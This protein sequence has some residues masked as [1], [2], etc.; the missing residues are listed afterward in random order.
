MPARRLGEIYLSAAQ[1][2]EAI[3]T[4][5]Y[6]LDA[7]TDDRESN[8]G[9]ARALEAGLRHDAA[10]T[11][12]RAVLA[13]EPG[14]PEVVIRLA[15][16]YLRTG[17]PQAALDLVRSSRRLPDGKPRP[18]SDAEKADLA[19]LEGRVLQALGDEEG[20]EQ[21]YRRAVKVVPRH[22]AGWHR[23]G[24]LAL[25]QGRVYEAQQA[26][27]A[28]SILAPSEP[29]YSVDL[30]RAFAAS[31]KPAEWRRAPEY[32]VAAMNR[33][34]RYAPAHYEAALWYIRQSRWKEALERLQMAAESEPG[35]PEI[36]EQLARVMEATGRRA[37]AL[38][39]RGLALDARS[40]RAAALVQYQAWMAADPGNPEAPLQVADSYFKMNQSHRAIAVLEKA[41]ARWPREET[42]RERLAAFY[43]LNN[44][45]DKA[46]ALVRE[47]QQEQP[48]SA[49]ATWML[50]RAAADE[51]RLDEALRLQEQALA[52]DPSN[53]DLQGTLGE[54][55]LKTTRPDAASRAVTALAKAASA[56]P[57]E[58]RWRTAL[59]EA[60]AKAGRIEEARRQALRAL[61]LDPHNGPV[62]NRVVQL[63]RQER[64]R[65]PLQLYAGLVRGV[66]A[67]LREELARWSATWQRPKD[68]DAYQALAMFLIRTG[69]LPA[70]EGQ[71]REALRLRPNW[72]EAAKQLAMVQRLRAVL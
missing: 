40:L 55:L 27:G 57:E 18:M 72:P 64:A 67:G 26:L 59:S 16:L 37:E 48:N 60:L 7:K 51:L 38:R 31:T 45:R 44:Q 58:A 24:L 1:P 20:A 70:A 28:A 25:A 54:L 68:P 42:L 2:F 50:A 21:S 32:F 9:L 23:R 4:F 65:P 35:N 12:L 6:A 8:L 19:V 71:L 53:G 34:L 66:E 30:G 56:A 46:R 36:Q 5:A 29:R 43:L 22:A 33:S 17:R 41:R 62:Y 49:L 15:E 3:W 47:W 52:R 61:D 69:D 13:R 63:A 39:R 11:R 10:V 14:Q